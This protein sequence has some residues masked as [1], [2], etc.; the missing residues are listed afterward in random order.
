MAAGTGGNSW[1]DLLRDELSEAQHLVQDIDECDVLRTSSSA[2]ESEQP[3]GDNSRIGS[4]CSSNQ[5][6]TGGLLC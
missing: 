5:P 4:H 3:D 1:D 2:C 6:R